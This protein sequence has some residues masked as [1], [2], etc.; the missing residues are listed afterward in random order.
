M[1]SL[2]QQILAAEKERGKLLENMINGDVKPQID[3]K[4][5]NLAFSRRNL[6]NQ[7]EV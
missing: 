6:D 1:E 3:A 5:R 2:R 7:G 4:V